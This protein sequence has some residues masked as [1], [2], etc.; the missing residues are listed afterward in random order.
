MS[1]VIRVS[2]VG[3][4]YKQYASHW[5]RFREWF[6]PFS[7]TRHHLHW[8][9]K[10]ISFEV[11]AGEAIG[12]VGSNG[13][14]KSTLLKMITGTSQ[15]TS[16]TIETRGDIAALLELGMGFHPEF[17]GRQNVYMAGQLRGLSVEEIT[18]LM[19]DIEAFAEIGEYIDQ[20]VRV[21]S[22]G[23]QVR[24]AF[25]VATAKR[26]V[27]L[28]VDEALSV[29]DAYFQ[30]KSFQRIREFRSEGTTLL[31]VTHDRSAIQSL[32]DRVILLNDGRIAKQG[33][34]EEV[35]DFYNALMAERE[36]QL[37]KQNV[38]EDG[39]V[40]TISGSG[41]V[42][43]E[44]IALFN[45][46]G[47]RIEMVLVGQSVV[48]QVKARV[49]QAVPRLVLGFMIKDRYGQ[50]IHGINTHRLDRGL[51][52]LAS[53]EVVTFRFGF[54]MNLG[55]GNYSIAFSLSKHD[56]HLETNYEWRDGGFIFHVINK[57]HPDFVGCT[58]LESELTID[59]SV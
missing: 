31:I 30:H 54:D 50:A 39:R 3:K 22:S 20:P 35:M 48:L 55:K 37:I 38:A 11:G 17:T 44:D 52:N 2:A 6:L 29:G 58:W 45:S 47:E 13:A 51:E 15:P 33:D 32:C 16:G 59:R 28:I 9:L 21:Y 24:L 12:I 41:E 49:N 40:S 18:E 5:D 19:P 23:M 34:A 42:S 53:G 27:V 46:A 36:Q 14:G 10:D 57:D 4:A 43:I 25:S 8:V 56:S 26:P 1:S 7:G